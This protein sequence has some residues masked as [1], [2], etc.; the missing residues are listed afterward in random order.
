MF[1]QTTLVPPTL[2]DPRSF[3]GA[4]PITALFVMAGT[5]LLSVFIASVYKWTHRGLSYSQAF[6]FSLVLLGMLGAGIMLV[7]STGVLPA[8]GI[9]AGF[10]LI[11]FRTPVKDPKDMAYILLVLVVGLAMGDRLYYVAAII[12]ATMCLTIIVLTR[13]NFGLTYSHESIVRLTVIHDEG[14]A[15]DT[16]VYESVLATEASSSHLLSA[17][18]HGSRMELTYGIRPKKGSTNLAVMNA[19]QS[20]PAVEHAEL[21]DA[22]HQVEF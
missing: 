11:R 14:V 6:Q 5:L 4:H 18:G 19:L 20:D 13:I 12:A 7:A 10:S 21:F 17:V 1:A 8:V 22:K 16:A 2:L 9:I 3:H 15:V